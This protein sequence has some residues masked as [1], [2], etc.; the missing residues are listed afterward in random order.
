MV[1]LCSGDECYHKEIKEYNPKYIE[2]LICR[3]MDR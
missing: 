3:E 1:C 2:L